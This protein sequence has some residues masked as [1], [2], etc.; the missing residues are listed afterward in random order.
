MGLVVVDVLEDSK[1]ISVSLNTKDRILVGDEAST[2]LSSI[3]VS[4]PGY[5]CVCVCPGAGDFK[6]CL[7]GPGSS[8]W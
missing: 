4:R 6:S 2:R 8:D 3:L 7:I 5:V 1:F